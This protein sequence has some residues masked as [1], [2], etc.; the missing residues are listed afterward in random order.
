MEKGIGAGVVFRH[1][2]VKKSAAAI[3][4]FEA[5]EILYTELPEFQHIE[6]RGAK[7]ERGETYVIRIMASGEF[8]EVYLDEVLLL[9]VL[10]YRLG[11]G[12][13]G[14]LVDRGTAEFRDLSI[15]PLATS[16]SL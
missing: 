2:D 13:I 15:S 1:M 10:R 6:A 9:Q 3:L 5:Q 4:D 14:L 7:L 12:Q 8:I 16:P 11:G